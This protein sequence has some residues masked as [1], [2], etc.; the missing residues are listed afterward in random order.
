MHANSTPAGTGQPEHDNDAAAIELASRISGFRIEQLEQFATRR[1]FWLKESEIGHGVPQ[2]L[3]LVVSVRD[4]GCRD[5]EMT[6]GPVRNEKNVRH[7][8]L[9]ADHSDEALEKYSPES[10]VI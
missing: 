9:C 4:C 10:V 5:V 7:E 8:W 3:Q 2:D 6:S 1:V